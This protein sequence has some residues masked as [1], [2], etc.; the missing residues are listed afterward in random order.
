MVGWPLS[1]NLQIYQGDTF[2]KVFTLSKN[3]APWPTGVLTWKAQIKDRSNTTLLCDIT[4]AVTTTATEHTIRLRIE[5]ES[6]EDIESQVGL[7]DFQ[8]SRA[9]DEWQ[10][11]LL[12]GKATIKTETTK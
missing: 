1:Y 4:I 5:A 9:S 3:G 11:T 7:W 2:E 10:K 6:T 8:V 12:A